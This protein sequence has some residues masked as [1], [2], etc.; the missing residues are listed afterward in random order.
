MSEKIVQVPWIGV[1]LDGTLAF[2]NG[3]QGPYHIGEP[4]MPMVYR[5]KKW[6]QEGKKVKIFTARVSNHGVNQDGSYVLAYDLARVK[7]QIEAF[8]FEHIGQI[9]EITNVKD[10]AMTELWD[11]RAV[12]VQFN[13]GFPCCN[14]ERIK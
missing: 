9:L 13:K 1:D 12:R 6:L 7:K 14:N 5:I 10:F 4:I 3:W 8:C 11:D 2:Y